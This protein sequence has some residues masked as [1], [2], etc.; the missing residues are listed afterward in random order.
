M[1]IQLEPVWGQSSPITSFNLASETGCVRDIRPS[2]AVI[3]P[4]SEIQWLRNQN[5]RRN[6][7]ANRWRMKW[8]EWILSSTG[9]SRFCWA[10]SSA[11]PCAFVIN[12]AGTLQ[13]R[14]DRVK[15]SV[16][17]YSTNQYPRRALR[18]TRRE[19]TC[20]LFVYIHPHCMHAHIRLSLY[21]SHRISIGSVS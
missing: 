6:Y 16:T 1:M 10:L 20:L 13:R 7:G 18:S 5:Q 8:N 14:R 12:W 11:L 17:S 4:I 2:D 9:V 15:V 19:C 3:L 21:Y